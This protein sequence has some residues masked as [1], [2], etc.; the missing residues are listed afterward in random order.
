MGPYQV[1]AAIAALH[2][3]TPSTVQT[4]WPQILALYDQL[5]QFNDNPMAHLSRA[6]ACAMVD[7]AVAGLAALDVL[8]HDQRLQGSYR[9]DAARAHL[10]ERAGQHA[11][12]I[13]LYRDA[14]DKT[15]NTA[16][17]TYL[18]VRAAKLVERP[19]LA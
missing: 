7:G 15:T 19:D 1:Q 4:D 6:I 17:R 11:D 3:Q 12:A 10:L 5:L 14:A 18:L 8:A 9:V 13:S 16:E 2:S